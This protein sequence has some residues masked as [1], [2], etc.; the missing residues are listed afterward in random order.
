MTAIP[1]VLSA[2]LVVFW[3]ARRYSKA[4]EP[5]HGP[6]PEELALMDLAATG[7]LGAAT[8]L[9]QRTHADDAALKKLAASDKAAAERL[10]E[11]RSQQVQ[12]L[13]WAY[14]SLERKATAAGYSEEKTS[15]VRTRIETLLKAAKRDR[16][17][18]ERRAR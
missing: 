7:D 17:W 1:F 2:A 5:Q 18:A 6:G 14:E 3:L 11:R 15:Q 12:A 13:T 16:D 10:L 9:I 8:E 4:E